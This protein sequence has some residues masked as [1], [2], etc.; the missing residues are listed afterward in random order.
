MYFE[1]YLDLTSAQEE[2]AE[3]TLSQIK[4]KVLHAPSKEHLLGSEAKDAKKR[5]DGTLFLQTKG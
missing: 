4:S 1:H 3:I 2:S 5:R